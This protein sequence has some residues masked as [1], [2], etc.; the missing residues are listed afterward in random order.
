M[1][2]RKKVEVEA[3]VKGRRRWARRPHTS[4]SD[5]SCSNRAEFALKEDLSQRRRR[6]RLT[7]WSRPD[8][9]SI[10]PGPG[11]RLPH[12]VPTSLR[13]DENRC[14]VGPPGRSDNSRTGW[15]SWPAFG[16]LVRHVFRPG[17]RARRGYRLVHA[18]LLSCCGPCP[19]SV[20]AAFGAPLRASLARSSV[21]SSLS[22]RRF[23]SLPDC[24][25]SPSFHGVLLHRLT[26]RLS[27]PPMRT[28]CSAN[29]T[30]PERMGVSFSG[31]RKPL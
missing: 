9:V 12:S 6:S 21:G 23:P 30:P 11:A 25:S 8:E 16:G 1:S 24:S 5:V 10:A 3:C 28:A 26:L 7:A 4:S 20:P 22:Q 29:G 15:G 18:S 14:T 19:T 17:Q 2:K 13:A 31:T 27:P